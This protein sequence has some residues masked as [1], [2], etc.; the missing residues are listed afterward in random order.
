MPGVVELG[1]VVGQQ[2]AQVGAGI[3]AG[4]I[5]RAHVGN[6][7]HAGVGAHG[8][9]FLDLRAVVDGHL[10]AGEIDH[11]GAGGEVGIVEGSA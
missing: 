3:G 10:P 6:I 2:M 7:E 1:H 9:V 5:Q 11:L 4:E 8:V